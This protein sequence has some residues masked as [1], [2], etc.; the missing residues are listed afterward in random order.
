MQLVTFCGSAG[1][2]SA[3]QALLD[4]IDRVAVDRGWTVVAAGDLDGIPMFDPAVGEDA[5]PRA[6]TMLRN[7]FETADAVVFAI[8]EYGGGAAGWAKNALDW[9]VGS[10]S[11]H[12][13][14]AAVV[15]AG[16]TGGPNAVGQI[17]RT[18]AWQGAHVVAA[19]GV[20][21]PVTKRDDRGR[22]IDESTLGSLTEIVG[23]LSEASEDEVRRRELTTET[24]GRL[25]IPL[26]DRTRA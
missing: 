25:G 4:V 9:M 14:I 15:C 11:L 21:A 7:S 16:T 19:L 13:R 8:P 1:E 2:R 12:D 10:G 20:A 26:S 23:F 18:L 24:L 17:A 3:N 6:V 5:A 22:I